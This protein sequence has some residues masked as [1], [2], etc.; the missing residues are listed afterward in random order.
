LL[1]GSQRNGI[2]STV[3]FV[4]L[5]PFCFK[6]SIAD[7]KKLGEKRYFTRANPFEVCHNDTV[8]RKRPLW[9]DTLSRD[10]FKKKSHFFLKNFSCMSFLQTAKMRSLL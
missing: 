2:R 4:L 8:L 6:K 9:N 7:K 1:N 3:P 10:F 5:Y